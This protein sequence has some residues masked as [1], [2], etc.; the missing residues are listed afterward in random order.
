M[1]ESHLYAVYFFPQA[2]DALG[3]AIKPYLSDGPAGP[4]VLCADIDSGGPFFEMTLDGRSADGRKVELEVMV[5]M[6]MVRCVI[7]V[8]GGDSE[9]GFA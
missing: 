9:F 5:P 4:H 1:A 8:H 3:E 6:A 2:L 7:S